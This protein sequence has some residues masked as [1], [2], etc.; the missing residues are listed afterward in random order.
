[1]PINQVLNRSSLDSSNS[2]KVESSYLNLF[3]WILAELSGR[4]PHITPAF[5]SVAH[6]YSEKQLESLATKKKNLK[7][8]FILPERVRWSKNRV[9]MCFGGS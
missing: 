9:R 6:D 5:Q 8:L 2:T 7:I 4:L 1:M 3:K